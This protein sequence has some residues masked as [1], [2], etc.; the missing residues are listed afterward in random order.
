MEKV[1]NKIDL[2]KQVLIEC[3]KMQRKQVEIARDAMEKVQESANEERTGEEL[4]DS[5]REQCQIDRDMYA[6]Q[7]QE[8]LNILNILQ[9]IDTFKE[10][11]IVEFGSIVITDTQ[12][13][14]VSSSIG[15]VKVEDKNYIAIST[16]SPFYKAMEG[17]SKGQ[18]FT[19]RDKTFKIIDVF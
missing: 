8:A 4:T 17:K 9:K 16:H 12:N 7:L 1:L 18:T 15:Q 19:F 5:F 2:K 6:R 13:L 14:F 3:L 10:S 11:K